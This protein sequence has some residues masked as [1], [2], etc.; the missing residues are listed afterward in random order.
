MQHR[1]L[2]CTTLF[3]ALVNLAQE[4]LKHLL[5]QSGRLINGRDL[6]ADVRNHLLLVVL[7]D[8]LQVELLVQS[9]H[10]GLELSVLSAVGSVE[11][12]A[13]LGIAAL[14]GLVDQPRA[15]VVLDIGTDFANE[16]RVTV[17]IQVVVLDLEVLTQGDEDIMGDLK[18]LGSGKLEVV[19]RQRN[20]EVETVVCRLIGDNEHV[21]VHGEVV[22]VD[23]VLGSCNQVAQLAQF[24]LPGDLVEKFEEV[25]VG[26]VRAE[27]L[28]EDHIDSGL[29]HEGVVDGDQTDSVLAVPAGLATTGDGAVHNVIA[30]QEE[31][32]KQLS[33]PAQGAEVLELLIS[34]RLFQSQTGVGDGE[35]AIQLSTRDID[36][37]G[38]ETLP[39]RFYFIALIP[40]FQLYTFSNHWRAF[41]GKLYF[42]AWAKRSWA[43]EGKT[44][45]NDSREAIVICSL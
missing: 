45:S 20:G 28:L 1:Y 12:L 39:V 27:V 32:L 38:L 5:L 10:L 6:I 8:V 16:G 22:E 29:E 25:D 44:D 9:L 7:V 11:Q 3:A 26:R 13:L 35:T 43:N 36:I 31:S 40:L 17:R 37:H 42:F 41:S 4:R 33:E 23:I 21:L 2:F 19:Q 30:D 18:V 24:R 14:Q 34:E 15:L